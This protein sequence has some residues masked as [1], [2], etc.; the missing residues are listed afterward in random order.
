MIRLYVLILAIFMPGCTSWA[1]WPHENF[2][3]HYG[4][5][6]GKRVDDPSTSIARY[7]EDIVAKRVLPNGNTEFELLKAISQIR[8]AQ[9]AVFYEVDSKTNV[10]VAWRFEGDEKICAMAP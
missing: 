7:P 5:Q 8:D 10:I 4:S 6:V 2:K 9:C 1:E 3:R